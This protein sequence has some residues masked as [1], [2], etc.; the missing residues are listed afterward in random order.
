[1]LDAPVPTALD[2][3]KTGPFAQIRDLFAPQLRA[4]VSAETFQAAWE[5]ELARR[6]P[7]SSVG[8][9]VSEPAIGGVVVVKVP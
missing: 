4:L 9:P 6:G 2:M 3:L 7:V 8:E 5:A 1:M